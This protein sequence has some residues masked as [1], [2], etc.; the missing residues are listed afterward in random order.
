MKIRF[1]ERLLSAMSGLCMIALGILVALWGLGWL[2]QT[3]LEAMQGHAFLKVLVAV[4]L[5]L[6]GMFECS[7]LFRRSKGRKGFVLQNTENGELSI[8]IKA[9]ESLVKK[10]V[11]K[12]EEIHVLS[13]NISSGRNGV[14]VSMRIGLANGVSIPL[15]VNSLQKQIKQYITA[16]SGV[17]VQEVRVQ[18]ETASA[19]VKDSPYAVPE[20]EI[21]LEKEPD[22]PEA[23]KLPV[24]PEPE[25]E[26]V[27]T[28]NA[29]PEEMIPLHQRLFKHQEE[30]EIIPEPPVCTNEESEENNDKQEENSDETV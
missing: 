21:C 12:H 6:L 7:L 16:C 19:D 28:V 10:C 8:S 27:V 23:A 4:A 18:V 14:V 26:P 2:P 17:D 20:V 25:A 11:D 15:A 3:W 29:Q 5:V 22:V 1:V 24:M 30:E 13:T 9:M